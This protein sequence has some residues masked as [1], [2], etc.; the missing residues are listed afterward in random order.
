MSASLSMIFSCRQPA[1]AR[2][3][4]VDILIYEGY[5]NAKAGPA[6]PC[7]DVATGTRGRPIHVYVYTQTHK[8]L[9]GSALRIPQ[10]QQVMPFITAVWR[11]YK[12]YAARSAD[13]CAL[14]AY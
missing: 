8:Q 1:N 4:S 10:T 14:S 3:L 6:R 9:I 11:A 12:Y 13:Y 2:H 7:A 5:L